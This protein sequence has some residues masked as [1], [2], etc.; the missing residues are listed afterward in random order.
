[1]YFIP[2]PLSIFHDLDES[3]LTL[4]TLSACIE[5]DTHPICRSQASVLRMYGHSFLS[6]TDA[7]GILSFSSN[8]CSVVSISG[9]LSKLFL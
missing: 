5:S 7:G 1:M 2:V 8:M 3:S 9:Q 6:Q 4:S